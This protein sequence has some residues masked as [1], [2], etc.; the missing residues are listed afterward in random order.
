MLRLL[1]IVECFR[2]LYKVYCLRAN[3]KSF[4]QQ[5]PDF[6]LPPKH[7]AYDAYATINWDY[8]YRSGL[9]TAKD[10]VQI[11]TEYN[12]STDGLRILEWGCGPGRSIR[13][14][15][16]LVSQ[17]AQVYGADYN[18]KTVRWCSEH[19]IEVHFTKNELVPP[20]PYQSEHFDFVYAI[21]VFTHLSMQ[22]CI[23]WMGEIRRI[24]KND[25]ILFFTTHSDTDAQFLLSVERERYVKQGVCTRGKVKEG[26]KMFGT[27]HHPEYIRN[28]L[29]ADFE[30]LKHSPAGE[31]EYIHTQD[32]WTARKGCANGTGNEPVR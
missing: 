6:A 19:I 10:L 7:L 4:L 30:L 31:F 13:H 8:Y 12:G 1:D 25:G 18:E 26:K 9:Q 24:L 20:L 27:W 17:D 2:F 28:V 32:A 3:N 15:P 14:L 21:S 16:G 11:I 29:L 22:C 5:H 23:D